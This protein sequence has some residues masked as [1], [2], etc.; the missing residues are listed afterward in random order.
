MKTILIAGGT[1]LIGR[2]LS[3]MLFEKGYA[4]RLL[5]RSPRGERQYRWDTDAGFVDEKALEGVD[6]VINLA[7]A[8]IADKRWTPAR[9]HLLIESRV[10]SANTLL[11]AFL[12]TGRKPAVYLSASAIGYYG[13]SG[14]EWMTETDVPRGTGF[15]VDCCR[16]WEN[17]AAAVAQAGIRTAI[18]RIGIV[19]ALEGG[20]LPEFVKPLYLG[21][22]GY[23]AEGKSWYSWIHLDDVCRM[24]IWALENEEV[25]GVYNAVAPRPARNRELVAAI[26]KAMHRR[27]IFVPAPTFAMRF[28]LGELSAA[29]LNS[30]R[31]SAEKAMKAGFE[32][33]YPELEAA[34]E[35][36]FRRDTAKKTAEASS[37]TQ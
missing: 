30:N 24:F 33:Q 9:K 20:A 29:I 31:I 13:N 17:A 14:E 16:Q 5:S 32:F 27:A 10:R 11:A 26:A 8:G 35:A 4:V 22:G 12:R 15:M 7:G 23:F 6:A 21:V 25:T 34:L 1:G 28:A 3:A 36:I 37:K 2:R 19:L 18:L